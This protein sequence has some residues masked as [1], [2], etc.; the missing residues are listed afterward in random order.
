VTAHAEP[1]AERNSEP[2]EAVAPM[3]SIPAVP[4]APPSAFHAVSEHDAVAEEDAHRP[5]RR[6]RHGAE[7]AAE[8]AA[9]LQM[10][11]TQVP[12]T[13]APP[14]EDEL[15]RRT[16]PRRRRGGATQDEPLQMVETQPG[17]DS[18][19]DGTPAQ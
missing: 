2:S 11:E 17:T 5:V 6:R 7:G 9:S 18:H 13:S 14:V 1:V 15:P 12:V 16:K 4:P 10:V 3:P 19:A 8:A